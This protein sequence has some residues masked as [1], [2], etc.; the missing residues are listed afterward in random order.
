MFMNKN[1]R[2]FIG[3][4]VVCQQMDKL[5][6]KLETKCLLAYHN[7]SEYPNRDNKSKIVDMEDLDDQ[8]NKVISIADILRSDWTGKKYF[9]LQKSTKKTSS[10]SV[11][12]ENA[13]AEEDQILL[14][15]NVRKR[16]F[17]EIPSKLIIVRNISHV[18]RQE[19][20]RSENEY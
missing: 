4:P 12:L 16:D 7:I 9:F 20:L 1:L 3:V 5:S 8:T 18:V 19:R 6:V 10:K 2:K 15:I 17:C 14:E 11:S 13:V